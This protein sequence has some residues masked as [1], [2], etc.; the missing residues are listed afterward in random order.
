MLALLDLAGQFGRAFQEAKRQEGG[1]DYHD[2]EQFA[3]RLLW[4]NGRPSD[5][6]QLWREKLRLILWMNTRTS[7]TPRR[8]SSKRSV[9]RAAKPTVPGR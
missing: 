6:A 1:I 5:I 4:K 7:T 9:V 2:L 3:L 8:P